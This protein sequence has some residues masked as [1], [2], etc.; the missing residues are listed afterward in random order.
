MA[1]ET[2]TETERILLLSFGKIFR[3][4]L[5]LVSRLSNCHTSGSNDQSEREEV[6]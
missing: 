2:E 3:T 4:S 1:A 6:C 5:I